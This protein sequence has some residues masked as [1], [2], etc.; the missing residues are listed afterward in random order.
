MQND[1]IV[2]I[3]TPEGVGAIGVIR[4]SGPEAIGVVDSVFSK[5]L[6]AAKGHSLHFGEI[7]EGEKVLDEVLVSI[8][9]GPRSYTREDVAEVS[10]HGSPYIL[11]TALDLF[12]RQGARLAQPGEFTQRAYLNGAFDL[13]QAEA[14]ADL[15][16][17]SSAKAHQL[18]LAQMRGGVSDEIRRLRTELL[19]LTSLFEL[20]L[21]FAE[22]DVEFADRTQLLALIQ[23]IRSLAEGL[24]DTFRLGN[25]IR[26]GI[27][28]VIAGRPNAGKSTLL[29]TL[30]Q[31]E[32]AIVSDIPGTTR[33]TIEERLVINGIVFRIVDTAGIREAQD[34]IEAIG[35]E[36]TLQSIQKAQILVYVYDVV[37]T[38][39]QE[40]DADLATLSQPSTPVIL[41]ANK[42]DEAE[43]LHDNPYHQ[44]LSSLPKTAHQI[45]AKQQ[46]GITELKASLYQAGIGRGMDGTEVIISNTRHH[47]ALR[48]A[49]MALKDAESALT[50]GLSQELVAI[51]IRA[52]I[53]Y[54]GEITG[55]ITTDEVLGNIFGK[56]CI[57]K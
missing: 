1:T 36:R 42:W 8:F 49:G 56:F 4:L 6:S 50:A 32:R 11:R 16:A 14:V 57:G 3:T 24:A 23:K 25:A 55:E 33:D 44:L 19:D 53:R 12:L 18:A 46:R 9:R 37:R 34:T 30:L 22:E 17:S 21:D 41:V 45:S 26:E 38:T 52:A 47:D 13:A 15:I 7:L 5:D 39:P 35:V 28:T 48:R 54:L 43:S 51:D 29:N 27:V 40:R 2:A 10:F 31:E 20:E